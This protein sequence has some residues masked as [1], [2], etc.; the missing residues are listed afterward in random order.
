[1]EGQATW[2]E[3]SRDL[4][5]KKYSRSIEKVIFELPNGV[6]SDYY[7]KKEGPTVSVLALTSKNEVILFEQFRPGPKKILKELPGGGVDEGEITIDAAK[8]ELFE[9]TGY[10]GKM[11]FVTMCLDDA[12]STMERYCFVA[13]DCEQVG[14][15]R[16]DPDEPGNVIKMPVI[17][18][19]S[20][21]RSGQLTDI[22]TGYLGLDYL[23]LL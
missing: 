2:K 12:Y 19:R 10:K 5:Y 23:G 1:M 4:D 18:F 3:V 14:N 16:H 9:E 17:E 13:T 11:Q 8:R 21:L 6:H 22:E 20:M 7:I 15:A